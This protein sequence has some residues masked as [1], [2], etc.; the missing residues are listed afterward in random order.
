[1]PRSKSDR[2]KRARDGG[3]KIV[4]AGSKDGVEYKSR[5]KRDDRPWEDSDG[6]RYSGPECDAIVEDK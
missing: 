5:G 3:A 1:M 4:K 6:K 2:L